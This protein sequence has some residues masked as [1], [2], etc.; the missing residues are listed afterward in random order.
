MIIAIFDPHVKGVAPILEVIEWN[1]YFENHKDFLMVD[2][3]QFPCSD[4]TIQYIYVGY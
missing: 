2:E 4:M 3:K 1:I